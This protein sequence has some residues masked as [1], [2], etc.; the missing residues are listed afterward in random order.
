MLSKFWGGAGNSSKL[1]D[2]TTNNLLL[3]AVEFCCSFAFT[4][5]LMHIQINRKEKGNSKPCKDLSS[6]V[7]SFQL[8]WCIVHTAAKTMLEKDDGVSA[9]PA[10]EQ[11][12]DSVMESITCDPPLF[13]VPDRLLDLMAADDERR[14]LAAVNSLGE[15]RKITRAESYLRKKF[16][17][18]H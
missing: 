10:Q 1:E 11:T 9:P 12:R 17:C 18:S 14:H 4:T 6:F 15:M 3:V 5:R 2:E 7:S 16:R 8:G 13:T